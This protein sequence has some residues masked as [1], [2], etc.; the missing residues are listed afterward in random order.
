VTKQW[1][2]R[3]AIEGYS[4]KIRY[5]SCSVKASCA[6]RNFAF[7]SPFNY[8]VLRRRYCLNEVYALRRYITSA[9]LHNSMSCNWFCSTIKHSDQISNWENHDYCFWLITHCGWNYIKKIN[10]F[11]NE[12]RNVSAEV[13][14]NTLSRYIASLIK[15]REKEIHLNHTE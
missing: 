13:I 4:V 6:I 12:L 10:T 15:D 9:N 5:H 1:S 2:L 7:H 11:V 3:K 8:Q 14:E